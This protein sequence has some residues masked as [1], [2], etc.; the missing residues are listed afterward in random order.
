VK[1]D[2][3]GITLVLFIALIVLFNSFFVVRQG[4]QTLTLYLGQLVKS[5][6]GKAK[7]DNPGLHF[8]IPFLSKALKFDVRIQNIDAESSRIPTDE[9]K[10]LLVDYYAKWRI[11]NLPLY[12]TR[13]G[14]LP[15]RATLLLTQKIND[16][17]RAAF[18]KRS[19]KEVVSA[20]RTDIMSIIKKT[21][22][23]S[24][25]DLGIH[26]V[27]TRIKGID[28]LQQV[29]DSV[30]QRMRTKREQV[31]TKYRYQGKAEAEK[32]RAEADAKARISIATAQTLAQETRASG[33]LKA[34]KLYTIAYSQNASFYSFYRSLRAYKQILAKQGT[35]MVLKPSNEFFKYLRL[36]THKH[37]VKP[38]TS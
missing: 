21:V 38:P 15:Q 6:D 3:L 19:L 24:A 22:N 14:G 35:I 29:Q 4:Q 33:D 36:T 7:I 28:L 34:S 17:L 32:I 23:Q 5:R 37:K 30:Y 8:K 13:T 1:V 11:D 25:N 27:D 26:V 12:Y 31:A 16:A 20:E 9:Q 18:G 2:F 10:Y